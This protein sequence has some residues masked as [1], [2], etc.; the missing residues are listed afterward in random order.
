MIRY[1]PRS[2]FQTI[3]PFSRRQVSV[4]RVRFS[5]M[6]SHQTAVSRGSSVT[7]FRNLPNNWG[8]RCR[9]LGRSPSQGFPNPARGKT[10]TFSRT[11]R[12]RPQFQ[13]SLRILNDWFAVTGAPRS[14]IP[15]D[16]SMRSAGVIET[17]GR[18]TRA[19]LI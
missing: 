9:F 15:W 7:A 8:G 11:R 14:M 2:L 6:S 10:G 4:L 12:L 3:S 5:S 19:G 13:T 16:Q 18:A 1:A 17:S